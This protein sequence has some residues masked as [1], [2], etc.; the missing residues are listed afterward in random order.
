MADGGGG[1]RGDGGAGGLDG[2][3]AAVAGVVRGRAGQVALGYLS[4][5]LPEAWS[6]RTG[7]VATL[8]TQHRAAYVVLASAVLLA[9]VAIAA[10]RLRGRPRVLVLA[11]VA[12]SVATWTAALVLNPRSLFDF[13]EWTPQQYA[14]LPLS[15]YATVSAALLVVAL[16]VLAD[17]LADALAEGTGGSVRGTRPRGR[18]SRVPR[19][20][21]GVLVGSLLLGWATGGEVGSL[22]D[23]GPAVPPQLPALAARC[24]GA[25]PASVVPLR[26]APADEGYWTL[27]LTCA[28]V[29]AGSTR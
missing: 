4:V 5:P 23:D 17:G 3:R 7:A 22:R 10:A 6:A 15:R 29:R 1:A 14:A 9:V 26:V 21:A 18:A 19:V 24:A 16:L 28:Q 13:T 25:A 8:V 2:A 27:P 12:G 11:L 20:A